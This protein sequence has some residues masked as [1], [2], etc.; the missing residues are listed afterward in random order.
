MK[1]FAGRAGPALRISAGLQKL[2]LIKPQLD[3]FFVQGAPSDAQIPGDIFHASGMGLDRHS[4]H[5]G[6]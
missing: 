6:H 3:D 4:D 2:V 1:K 5:L